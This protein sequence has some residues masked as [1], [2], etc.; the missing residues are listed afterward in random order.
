MSG[1]RPFGTFSIVSVA[2]AVLVLLAAIV[3]PHMAGSLLRAYLILLALV[4]VARR[5]VQTELPARHLLD[6]WSPF[7]GTL[8]PRRAEMPDGMWK[9]SVDLRLANDPERAARALV[10]GPVR[11]LLR[12]HV[13]RRLSEGFGLDLSDPE[14][15]PRIRDHL[16]PDAWELVAPRPDDADRHYQ[17][18]GIHESVTLD[19][20]DPVLDD[21]EK[22]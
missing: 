9:I 14:H 17:V 13:D 11:D 5:V 18:G 21:L 2:L 10:P 6:D 20:L 22:L 1:T 7:D 4:L 8:D 19:R 12:R 3:W 16:G 15:H